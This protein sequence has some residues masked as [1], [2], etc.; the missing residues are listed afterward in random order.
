M[1]RYSFIYKKKTYSVLFN[2]SYSLAE[3]EKTAIVPRYAI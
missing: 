3:F 2:W 1:L